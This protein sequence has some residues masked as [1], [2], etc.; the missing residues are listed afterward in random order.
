MQD[1]RSS[2]PPVQVGV[3]NSLKTQDS[4]LRV[5]DGT[6]QDMTFYRKV[7]FLW[8]KMALHGIFRGAVSLSGLPVDGSDGWMIFL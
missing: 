6:W 4:R 2:I 8:E 5:N 3:E 1:I 7:I